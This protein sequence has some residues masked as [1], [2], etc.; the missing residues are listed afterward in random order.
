MGTPSE[1]WVSLRDSFLYMAKVDKMYF[2]AIL[3]LIC[4]F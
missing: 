2:L 3:I 1:R 4:G